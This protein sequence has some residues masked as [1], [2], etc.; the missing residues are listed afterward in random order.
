M[1]I[2]NEISI[3]SNTFV[4]CWSVEN[5]SK[6]P[7]CFFTVPSNV[8]ISHI[9]SGNGHFAQTD[10]KIDVCYLERKRRNC[11]QSTK[12]INNNTKRDNQQK[13]PISRLHELKEKKRITK[14]QKQNILYL[15]VWIT[16]SMQD[17]VQMYYMDTIGD[18]IVPSANFWVM[19]VSVW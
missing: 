14:S 11:M 17:I 10:Y 19:Q 9:L 2:V 16:S 1:Y 7:I 13:S 18:Q 6:K 12:K 4:D 8:T 5:A 3:E 15:P